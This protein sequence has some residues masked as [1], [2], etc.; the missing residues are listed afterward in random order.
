MNCR[1]EREALDLRCYLVTSGTDRRT[2]EVA[3]LAAAAGAGVVQVR[4]KDLSTRDLLTL[5][6]EIAG[7]VHSV[8]PATTVLVDDRADVAYAARVA[9]A[10]VHG[11]HLGTD[12][13]PAEAARHLLGPEAIIGLTTG[14]VELALWAQEQAEFVD[15]IGAGPFR[16]TPT[17]DSGRQP[18]GLAGY[19]PIVSATRLPVVAIGDITTA[20]VPALVETGIA[21]VAL[22]RAV[23]DAADPA[24]VVRAVLSA[25]S[26]TPTTGR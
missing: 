22:V 11:V 26:P 8:A 17:K 14:T 25:Y 16:R 12:D 2:V 7:A 21:G 10:P 3:A 13:L 15:Y 4:A 9:G 24:H 20:D 19:P 6:Q 18:L 5:T 23:M 1:V